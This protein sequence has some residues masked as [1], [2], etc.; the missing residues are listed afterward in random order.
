[1]GTP[2]RR[3]TTCSVQAMVIK[4]VIESNVCLLPMI[5]VESRFLLRLHEHY[6][7]GH[8]ARVGGVLEQPNFYLEAMEVAH[9]AGVNH[10]AERNERAEQLERRE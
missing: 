1:V 4:N 6:K 7:K 5:T 2:L 8:M 3:N 10:H 9:G